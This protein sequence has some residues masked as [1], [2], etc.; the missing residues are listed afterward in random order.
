MPRTN[1]K[2]RT[3]LA[4]VR[5]ASELIEEGRTPSMP[6]AAERALVSVATAY[7]YYRSA[8]ELWN[9]AVS[10]D[11]PG[12][13]EEAMQADLDAAGDDLEARLEAVIRGFGFWMVDNAD[14][15]RR[16]AKASLDSLFAQQARG[17]EPKSTRP[18]R[19]V[20]WI[21]KAL[22]P[23]R[24]QL[25]D[26]HIDAIAEGVAMTW[27]AEPVITLLDVLDL[28]PE[29]AKERMRTTALWILRAGLAAARSD[30]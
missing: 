10:Y 14:F 5:A 18:R 22:E 21:A 11:S 25:E 7:R 13:D 29:A 3:R 8:E 24:G 12:L 1:Q 6:Q 9:D 27:G 19:R 17:E 23:L 15:A 28:S 30:A 4:L 20:T 2:A 26:H 16:S